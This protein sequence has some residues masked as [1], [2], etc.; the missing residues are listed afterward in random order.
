MSLEMFLVMNF[1]IS[2]ITQQMFKWLVADKLTDPQLKELDSYLRSN[3]DYSIIAF[4]EVTCNQELNS[5]FLKTIRFFL[6]L[7]GCIAPLGF[8]LLNKDLGKL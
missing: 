4:I 5:F 2:I 3:A 6:F 7:M 8:Y 1:L